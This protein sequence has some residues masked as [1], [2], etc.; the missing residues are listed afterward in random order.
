MTAIALPL[1]G[2]TEVD[3]GTLKSRTGGATISSGA[4]V[5]PDSN[6]NNELKTVDMTNSSTVTP[7]GFLYQDTIDGGGAQVAKTGRIID[8]FAGMT[9][10]NLYYCKTGGTIVD[11]PATDL[12][13]GDKIIT[14]GIALSATKLRVLVI[15]TGETV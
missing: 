14:A 15:D 3:T 12:T 4:M 10:W 11:D 6:D 9:A 1:S 5:G 7:E 2:I 8:G 13:S